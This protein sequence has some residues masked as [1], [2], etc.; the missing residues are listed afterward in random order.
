MALVA[1]VAVVDFSRFA[2]RTKLVPLTSVS[3][4]DS[5]SVSQPV[6]LSASAH[7]KQPPPS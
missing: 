5:Q 7:R 1:L 6:S 3:Q 2:E 4:P